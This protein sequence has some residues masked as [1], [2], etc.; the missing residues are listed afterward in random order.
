MVS[1]KIFKKNTNNKI[2]NNKNIV[3]IIG[4]VVLVGCIIVGARIIANDTTTNNNIGEQNEAVASDPVSVNMNL[5]SGTLVTGTVSSDDIKANTQIC[6]GS[7]CVN[8]SQL[9]M[10]NGGNVYLYNTSNGGSTPL[11]RE[12][13]GRGVFF[14]DDY[15]QN[16]I[17]R[18][19]PN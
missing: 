19:R 15:P 4:L 3:V 10:L 2:M 14:Y 7:A 1:R 16:A 18:L 12:H 9:K 5:G 8:E 17:W 13:K 6:I 11:R